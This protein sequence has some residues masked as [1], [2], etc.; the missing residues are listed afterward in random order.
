MS[1]A[2]C[3]FPDRLLLPKGSVGGT[4]FMFYFIVTPYVPYEITETSFNFDYSCGIG[5]GYRY[6]DH[7]PFGFPFD[8][9]IFFF[10]DFYVKNSFF[11]DVYVYEIKETEINKTH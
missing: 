4:P 3:G 2:H 6:I 8:R 10:D 7:L 9:E 11:K 5:S 1:E